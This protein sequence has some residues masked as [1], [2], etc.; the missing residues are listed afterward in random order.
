MSAPASRALLPIAGFYF[1]YYAAVGILLPFFPQHL[2][3]LGL[4]GAQMGLASAAGPLM[5][6]LSP[7][8]W[9][10]LADRTR[11]ASLLLSIG[12]G[13]YT[14]ALVPLL[15]AERLWQIL[16]LLLLGALFSTPLPTLTDSLTLQHLGTRSGGFARIRLF[17]SLGFIGS[18]TVFGLVYDG[19]AGFPPPVVLG[20]LLCIGCAFVVSLAVRGSGEHAPV[21]SPAEAW[22]LITDRRIALLVASTC[23]HWLACAPY[24]M[25]FAVHVADLG[26][27]PS[28]AGFGMG[29][30][31]AAEVAV[32]L[33]FPRLIRA[34]PPP[35]ILAVAYLASSLRWLLVGVVSSPVLLVLLQVLHGLTFG[36]FLLSAIAFLAENVP[37]RLRATGQAL[38]T[39]VTY[40]LGG[41]LGYLSAGALYEAI[42]SRNAFFASAAL[43][44]APLVLVLLLP[45]RSPAAMPVVGSRDP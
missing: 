40:G 4:S 29:A 28:V 36:A 8:V 34:L 12:A 6:L 27:P 13:S 43:E 14:L 26:L 33:A 2:R 35:R 42:G 19:G 7:P 20:A 41:I 24:H 38:Y 15:F 37:A 44:W 9:G 21:P 5:A 18:T 22:A 30:G 16:P 25:L 10:F 39:S 3:A 45:P 17:G 32:M 11:R 31:V 23:L 1:C